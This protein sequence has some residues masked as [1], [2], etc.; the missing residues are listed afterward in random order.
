MWSNSILF[1]SISSPLRSLS[2]SKILDILSA[3]NLAELASD[4]SS[5]I[6]C[7]SSM[8]SFST[9]VL[10]STSA[11]SSA[12]RFLRFGRVIASSAMLSVMTLELGFEEE[13]SFSLRTSF[14]SSSIRAFCLLMVI[15][16]PASTSS[17]DSSED[18]ESMEETIDVAAVEAVSISETPIFRIVAWS[19]ATCA[20]SNW[21]SR[22]SLAASSGDKDLM[23]LRV[24]VFLMFRAFVAYRSVVTV[25]SILKSAGLTQAT[26]MVL[27]FPPS[28]S[29]KRRVSFESR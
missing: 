28:E 9:S 8:F 19:S 27:E 10:A 23:T 22:W 3:A 12:T 18:T 24:A 21:F 11:S 29:C 13:E 14:S 7:W 20:L 16:P 2:C 17:P 26:I 25:S 4:F 5:F 6:S 1:F 15:S